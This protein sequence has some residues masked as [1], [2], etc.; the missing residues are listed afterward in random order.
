MQHPAIFK[1]G[2]LDIS[3][4]HEMPHAVFSVTRD[5]QVGQF[6]R[7]EGPSNLRS[8]VFS[9]IFIFYPPYV[10]E[11]FADECEMNEDR[12]NWRELRENRLLNSTVCCYRN[13]L[14]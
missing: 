5:L 13:G 14:T 9:K 1:N 11:A 4:S 7:F 6:R 2:R 12:A 3:V 8:N 10:V